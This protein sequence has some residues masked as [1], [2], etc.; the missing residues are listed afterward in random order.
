MTGFGPL[1][2]GTGI[3]VWRQIAEWIRTEAA[4][5]RFVPGMQLPPEME[6]AARFGVNRHTVRRAISV[7]THEGLLRADQGR[8]TFFA[9]RSV[10]YPISR[11]TRFS[12]ILAGQGHAPG[13]RL[14][15]AG[16]EGASEFL[17]GKLELP[18]GTPLQRIETLRVS[19]ETP[20]LAGT[21]WCELIRFPGLAADF[22]ETG[23]FTQCFTRAG[24]GGY[25]RRETR[26]YA[27]RATQADARL[28]DIELGSP[29]M[30]MEIVNEDPDGRP[31]QYA[32]SRVA[33]DRMELVVRS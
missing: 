3:A 26:I 25:Y 30:V 24:L 7:L 29:V 21:S 2:R 32:R 10:S 5:G 33:A 15:G 16:V 6:L 17:A 14:T 23:S 9:D 27:E 31:V 13:G 1:D 22:A 20:V 11:Q 28:L 12:E 4:T 8:G 19:G 18:A